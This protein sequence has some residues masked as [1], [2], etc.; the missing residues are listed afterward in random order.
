MERK[1]TEQAEAIFPRVQ[2]FR[3]HLHAHPEL[4]FAENRT[5][6]YIMD[7]LAAEG[8]AC[9]PI[10]GTGVLAVI[11]GVGD[12]SEAVMLRADIDA[13]PVTEQADVDFASE[14]EGVMHACGHD[15]HAAVLFGALVLLNRGRASIK[16][17]VL[18]LFQPGEERNPG[19]A[20]LVLAEQPFEGYRIRAFIGEHTE[21]EMPAGV[22]GFREGKYM[23]S[24]DELRITVYGKGGHAAMRAELKDPVAATAEIITGL[25]AIPAENPDPNTPS[26]VSI[27]RVEAGGATNVVP[28]EVYMEG[29]IRA[30]DEAWRGQM[31]DRIMELCAS[32]DAR[33]GTRSDIDI[34]TGFPSVVNNPELTRRAA[35]IATELFGTE[36]VEAL[37]IRPT[38]EDFGFYTQV[39]PSVFYRFGVGEQALDARHRSTTPAGRLHTPTLCPNEHSLP[40]AVA[41]MTTLAL[42][43]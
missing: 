37:D 9:R 22:F 27:G 15:M 40:S 11:E 43:L 1:I 19:G 33:Y 30:F 25:L 17:T 23:A 18:G 14:N 35:K 10:A 32:M 38:A 42:E 2:A 4:S 28:G 21:P 12:L 29:T 8:I 6:R 34:S 3:R 7:S 39:Y 31:K 20:S 41:L 36:A 5:Q 24:S 26:V 16:G 13:L